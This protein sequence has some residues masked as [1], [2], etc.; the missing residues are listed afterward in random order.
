MTK[1]EFR[2]QLSRR[3]FA[4]PVAIHIRSTAATSQSRK[5]VQR[6][7]ISSVPCQDSS[8]KESIP[9]A[10]KQTTRLPLAYSPSGDFSSDLITGLFALEIDF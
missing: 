5:C 3:A 9:A 2:Q 7:A 8:R 6:G 4:G 10:T 1:T